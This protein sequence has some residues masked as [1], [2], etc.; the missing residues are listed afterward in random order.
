MN[1]VIAVA[2]VLAACSARKAPPPLRE[3]R[4]ARTQPADAGSTALA[5]QPPAAAPPPKLAP[6]RRSLAEVEHL[7]L[8]RHPAFDVAG[9]REVIEPAYEKAAAELAAQIAALPDDATDLPEAACKL[10]AIASTDRAG[11][12]AQLRR[13][14][15]AARAQANGQTESLYGSLRRS[16]LTLDGKHVL[17]GGTLLQESG[18]ALRAGAAFAD[19]SRPDAGALRVLLAE[20]YLDEERYPTNPFTKE[21]YTPTRKKSQPGA[22]LAELDALYRDLAAAAP[23]HAGLASLLELAAIGYCD[24]RRAAVCLGRLAASQRVLALRERALPADD[25]VLADTRVQHARLLAAGQPRQAEAAYAR[26]LADA[27]PGAEARLHAALDLRM[28]RHARRDRA[29]ALALEATVI[30]D[31]ER[32]AGSQSWTWATLASTWAHLA[33]SEGRAA[34]AARILAAAIRGLS[35]PN[36]LCPDSEPCGNR[37]FSTALLREQAALDP[38]AAPA[39]LQQVA[40]IERSLAEQRAKHAAEVTQMVRAQP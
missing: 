2:L 10:A 39:L 30:A 27:A 14:V 9:G 21:T 7:E 26:V 33:G 32:P 3:A 12:E 15:A 5:E 4:P 23:D 11:I 17:R 19:C 1:R 29:G 16:Y 35:R 28:M 18:D 24:K 6:W 31:L 40:E 37:S 22:A 38:A 25:P 36:P 8:L 13:A 20:L 34:D